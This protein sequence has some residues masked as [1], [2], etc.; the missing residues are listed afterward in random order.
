MKEELE[1]IIFSK[2]PD[3]FEERKLPMTQTCMC[4]GLEA[5]TGWFYL[6]YGLCSELD[7]LGKEYDF[8]VVS[9][10]VKE[11]YGT[12]RFYHRVENGRKTS[13][14][15]KPLKFNMFLNNT[16]NNFDDL[17]YKMCR[18]LKIKHFTRHIHLKRGLWFYNGQRYINRSFQNG[19]E[20]FGKTDISDYVNARISYITNKYES[21]SGKI[22]YSC[23]TI[24][25]YDNPMGCTDGWVS[26][27][28]KDCHTE[29]MKVITGMPSKW[30]ARYDLPQPSPEPG[31]SNE[32]CLGD[33]AGEGEPESL[34]KE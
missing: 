1:N 15:Y 4:W 27:I 17:L 9:E 5:P 7:R 34:T 22:C 23:G 10:Q 3:M 32:P 25:T 24:G 31:I 29:H 18:K 13:W 21:L 8:T 11:K 26:Y 33:D 12:L 16:W 2:F 14:V 6:I 20:G 28:C 30:H 19:W